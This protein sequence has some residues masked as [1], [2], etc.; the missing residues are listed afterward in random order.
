MTKNHY[1]SPGSFN[2]YLCFFTCVC[3]WKFIGLF[4]NEIYF[5]IE[6]YE[7]L[8]TVVC[9]YCGHKGIDMQLQPIC[10]KI[11]CVVTSEMLSA[12]LD[13]NKCSDHLDHALHYL[14]G[15]PN[16]VASKCIQTG[17]IWFKQKMC[18][19]ETQT[20]WSTAP[21]TWIV[22]SCCHAQHLKNNQW[23]ILENEI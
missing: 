4:R 12:S 13:C 11:Q 21:T 5:F 17:T 8:K 19:M 16:K 20:Q 6:L 14:T 7:L 18:K 9:F 22:I 15:V 10:F 3:T 23:S 1:I 2:L